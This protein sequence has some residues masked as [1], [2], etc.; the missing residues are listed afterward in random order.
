MIL[1]QDQINEILQIINYNHIVFG[2]ENLGE[3]ELSEEDEVAANL[4]MNNPHIQGNWTESTADLL[5]EIE[6]NDR[7]LYNSLNMDVLQKEVD[8]LIP[9]VPDIEPSNNLVL[10]EP[11]WN[12]QCPCCKHKW[13]VGAKDIKIEDLSD[14]S[15][16]ITEE[17]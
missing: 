14:K 7:E 6:S 3:P 12:T 2:L 13:I 5:H 8:K 4:T 11:D 10:P 17:K 15:K 16:T 9:K 1:K